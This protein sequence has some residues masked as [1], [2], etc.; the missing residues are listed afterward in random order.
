[1][2]RKGLDRI[3]IALGI[4]KMLGI[5]TMAAGA[6]VCIGTVGTSDLEAEMREILHPFSW[7]VLHEA[8][9]IGLIMVGFGVE[10]SC[11]PLW[12]WIKRTNYI[13]EL[14]KRTY[15]ERRNRT[16]G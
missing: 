11:L 16:N 12:R 13:W 10:R 2:T 14:G 6:I 5:G 3:N 9:G 7:Y 8:I 1:M 4:T 15:N